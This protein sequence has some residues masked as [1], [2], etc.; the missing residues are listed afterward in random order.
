MK[1]LHYARMDVHF[2]IAAAH[3]IIRKLLLKGGFVYEEFI[4]RQLER[5]DLLDESMMTNDMDGGIW[6]TNN[7]EM[8]Q[9]DDD[10]DDERSI[11]SDDVYI[12]KPSSVR[13]KSTDGDKMVYERMWD[14]LTD[15][16][17]NG[18]LVCLC[19]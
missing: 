4:Q 12:S 3:L 1:M 10:V 5:T 11:T 7:G 15:A 13:S 6:R 8:S 16:A 14:M 17:G 9:S 18:M 19:I 2:L